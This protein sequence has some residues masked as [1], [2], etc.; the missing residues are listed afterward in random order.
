M[1]GIRETVSRLHFLNMHSHRLYIGWISYILIKIV[2]G[3][4]IV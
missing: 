4:I 3:R 2:F 1:R